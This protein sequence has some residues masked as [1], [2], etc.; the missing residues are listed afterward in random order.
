MD[1]H[2]HERI[3][4]QKRSPIRWFGSKGQFVNQLAIA[5]PDDLDRF[6]DGFCGACAFP[7]YLLETGRLI[8]SQLHLNDLNQGLIDFWQRISSANRGVF[9]SELLDAQEQHCAGTD[10][11]FDISEA[12]NDVDGIA[13]YCQNVLSV[14]GSQTCGSMCDP[15]VSGHGLKRNEI[16]KLVSFGELLAGVKF[17]CGDYKKGAALS[18]KSLWFLDSP[19]GRVGSGKGDKENYKMKHD[20]VQSDY[21]DYCNTI[22]DGSYVMITHDDRQEIIDLFSGWHIYRMPKSKAGVAKD[23]PTELL[24]TNYEIPYRSFY[25]LQEDFGVEKVGGE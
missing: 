16:R 20:F 9:V 22:K 12:I 8:P 14:G 15:E 2:I 3:G 21:A 18:N 4:D 11:L 24:I 10:E 17:T 1:M 6:I 23:M 25:F 7:M 5:M 13:F 19:Y